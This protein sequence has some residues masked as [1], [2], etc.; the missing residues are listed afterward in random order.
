MSEKFKQKILWS[1]KKDLQRCSRFLKKQ[2]TKKNIITIK[3]ISKQNSS[4]F[5]KNINLENRNS[6]INSISSLK[7]KR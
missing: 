3:N 6:S 4:S 2:K 5:Y 1:Q 7:K